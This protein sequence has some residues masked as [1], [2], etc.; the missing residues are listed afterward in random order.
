MIPIK[1]QCGCGQRYAFDV[2]PVN[3]RMS[4][5]VACP[6]CGTDGTSVA[7]GILAQSAPP[8]PAVAPAPVARLHVSTAAP[9]ATAQPAVSAPAPRRGGPLPGQVDPAKAQTEARSKIFWGDPP[10]DVVRFLMMN[11]FSRD[12][13]TAAVHAMTQERCV[14]LRG[15]GIRKIVVGTLLMA[16]PVATFFYFMYI[17]LMLVKLLAMTI[18]VGLWGAWMFLKGTLM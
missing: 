6:V 9:A 15:I 3:G 5:A 4:W 16:V 17:H 13:A 18:V 12:D 1:I 14:T 7:N 8:P 11:G 2:E 10:E